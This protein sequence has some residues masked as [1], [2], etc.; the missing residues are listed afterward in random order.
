[1]EQHIFYGILDTGYV[2]SNHW[3]KKCELLIE[4]GAGIIQLRAKKQKIDEKRALLKRILPLFDGIDIPLIINDEIELAL[5]YPKL[6]L[7]IGQDDIPVDEARE[8]LGADRILGLS[9]HSEEQVDK[10]L[11]K[12]H[13]LDYFAV[14]PVFPTQTKPDYIP[15]GLQLVS[16]AN[17][18]SPPIPFYCIGGINRQNASTVKQ[19]GG[20]GIVTV[21]DVLCAIDTKK[22]VEETISHFEEEAKA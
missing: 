7:H 20:R 6:G 18:K 15:V 21:S 13:L 10:A 19:A 17:Q 4:G 5:E 2:S 12:V 14:G 11:E 16:Y 8:R 1:M 3:E 22:A 9:T